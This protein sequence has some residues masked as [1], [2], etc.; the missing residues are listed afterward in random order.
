MPCGEDVVPVAF[1]FHPYLRC[2]A[3]RASSGRSSCRR[4]GISRSTPSRSRSAPTGSRCPAAA[5]RARR[6]RVRRRLRLASRTP[7]RF[8]VSG[9]RAGGS[10]SSSCDGYP[11]RAGLR[12]AVRAL[13]LLRADD[14]ARQR[15]AQRATGSC[16]PASLPGVTALPIGAEV[17]S[18]RPPCGSEA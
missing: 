3:A 4:C 13:H 16:R 9:R 6:A 11:V 15:A 14:R 5:L 7:A 10:S 1:G 8:A 17:I 2:R 12:A 18:A